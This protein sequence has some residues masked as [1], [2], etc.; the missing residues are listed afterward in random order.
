MVLNMKLQFKLNKTKT[1]NNIIM[2]QK[3]SFE[4]ELLS[5]H[6]N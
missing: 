2:N 1:P 3:Y 5:I 4:N 6:R